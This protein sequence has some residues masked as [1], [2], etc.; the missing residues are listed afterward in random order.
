MPA[1]TSFS[2]CLLEPLRPA[3]LLRWTPGWPGPPARLPAG[4]PSRPPPADL[5]PAS[6]RPRSRLPQI[7]AALLSSSAGTVNAGEAALTS[8][9]VCLQ[10]QMLICAR[11][12]L[13][14]GR[15]I[16]AGRRGRLQPPHPA[17]R[18]PGASGQRLHQPSFCLPGRRVQGR[19]RG[20]SLPCSKPLCNGMR[21]TLHTH[22]GVRK[23]HWAGPSHPGTVWMVG[24]GRAGG[25][26]IMPPRCANRW[27]A[28]GTSRRSA[29]SGPCSFMFPRVGDGR[30]AHLMDK[31]AEL[32]AMNLP[33]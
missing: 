19:W 32:R 4:G 10:T 23:R 3:H 15:K 5:G 7:L 13:R 22:L 25:H 11:C 31:K 24:G 6:H 8:G 30:D 17:G 26:S 20:P 2:L 21:C 18:R 16:R 28:L 14:L 9:L 1:G 29:R 33:A 12:L 27:P